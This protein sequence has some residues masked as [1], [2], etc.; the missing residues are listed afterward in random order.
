MDSV[1]FHFD[2]YAGFGEVQGIA[3][4]DELGLEL[5][6]STRDA[7]LGVLKTSTRR[8][9]IPV[10]ALLSVRYRAGWFWLMPTIELRVR[11]LSVVKGLPESEQGRVTLSLKLRDR[12]DGRAFAADL[13]QMRLHRRIQ[14]LDRT[15]E[16]L[17]APRP[18][19]W[20]QPPAPPAAPR[21]QP[22][23]TLERSAE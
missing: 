18:V 10:E 16:H 2:T 9:R 6:F 14:H 19:D 13:E 1:P 3:R 15:L 23:G 11:E 17:M 22:P 20:A 21:T 5:Q 8:V 12:H 4:L 7:L